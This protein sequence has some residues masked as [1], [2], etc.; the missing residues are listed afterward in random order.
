MSSFLHS[1]QGPCALGRKYQSCEHRSVSAL[2]TMPPGLE[3]ELSGLP[4]PMPW[5]RRSRRELPDLRG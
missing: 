4:V 3:R 2:S 1:P 5:G